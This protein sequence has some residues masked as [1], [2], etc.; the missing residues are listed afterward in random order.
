M[1]F[2]PVSEYGKADPITIGLRDVELDKNYAPVI[3]TN[4][5]LWRYLLGRYHSLYIT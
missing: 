5:G 2:M 1:E 4:G 3:S